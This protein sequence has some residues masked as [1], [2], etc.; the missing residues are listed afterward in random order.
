MKNKEISD[1]NIFGRPRKIEVTAQEYRSWQKSAETNIEA[2][3]E[4]ITNGENIDN[5]VSTIAE[6]AF[7][8]ATFFSLGVAYGKDHKNNPFLWM[9][10][11]RGTYQS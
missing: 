1:T 6:Q 9:S 11:K 7:L 10:R 4:G 5:L 2:I 8:C 3:K